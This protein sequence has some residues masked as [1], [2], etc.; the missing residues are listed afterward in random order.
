MA[1]AD[2]GAVSGHAKKRQRDEMGTLVEAFNEMAGEL[3]ENREVITRSTAELRRSNRELDARRR[4]IETLLA[5]LST[6]VVS[7]G[8][9][10]DGVFAR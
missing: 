2:P 9:G 3:Q 5:N 4:Y 10:S 1:G 7:P 6:A 8:G